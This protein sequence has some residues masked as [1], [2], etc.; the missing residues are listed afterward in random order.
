MLYCNRMLGG[1]ELRCQRARLAHDGSQ[2]PGQWLACRLHLLCA[3]AH[4]F[5]TAT[6]RAGT[7]P[8]PPGGP[9]T[10]ANDKTKN[11]ALLLNG[12]TGSIST[13]ALNLM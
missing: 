9:S 3:F 8:Q 4:T 10:P 12:E 6:H 11:V 2:V 13:Q 5:T 1:K 7:A